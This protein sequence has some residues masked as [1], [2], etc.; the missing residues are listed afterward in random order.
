MSLSDQYTNQL[1][2]LLKSKQESDRK[3]YSKKH[4]I[5]RQMLQADP[6]SFV[7]DSESG[8]IVGITH[9]PTGFRM[10]LPKS[11]LPDSFKQKTVNTKVGSAVV[12]LNLE[13][14]PWYY[15]APKN[16]SAATVRS[17]SQYSVS[18]PTSVNKENSLWWMT[19]AVLGYL[20]HR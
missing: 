19:P 9:K 6:D 4:Y 3:N 18:Q 11:V 17:R 14:V 1:H 20:D 16:A 8:S 5:M 12:G 10:H 7:V 13:R 15:N 2:I